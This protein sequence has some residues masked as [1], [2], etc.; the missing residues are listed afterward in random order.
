MK[1]I[2]IKIMAAMMVIGLLSSVALGIAGTILNF[3]SANDVM[4]KS[5]TETAKVAA[6]RVEKELQL[7]LTIATELGCTASVA[8]EEGGSLKRAA[9]IEDRL[10]RYGLSS[11]GI[12]GADGKNIATGADCSEEEF[13]KKAFDGKANISDFFLESKLMVYNTAVAAAPIWKGG[14]VGTSIIGVVYIVPSATFFEELAASIKVGEK[15][16]AYLL[17]GTGITM[18][19]VNTELVGVNSQELALEDASHKSRAEVEKKMMEGEPGF[20]TYTF[21]GNTEYIAYAPIANTAGWTIGINVE[22]QEFLG[23]VYVSLIINIIVALA[24]LVIAAVVSMFFANAIAKPITLCAGRLRKLADGDLTSPVPAATTNDE[25]GGLV[26][27]MKSVITELNAAIGDVSENLGEMANGNFALDITAEYK[28]DFGKIKTSLETIIDSLNRTLKQINENADQVS[29]GAK[30]VSSGANALSI[31]ATQQASSV[32]ELA[33]T[34]TELTAQAKKN[35]ESAAS[36][37][38]ETDDTVAEIIASREKMNEVTAAMDDI[39]D[40]SDEIS[41]IIRT[42]EDIAFQTNILALNAAVEAARAGEAGKGFAVVADEVRNLASKSAEA[43]NTTNALIADTVA[44]VNNGNAIVAETAQ[45]L[46]AVVEL[47]NNVRGR[48]DDIAKQSENQ[49]ESFA[50]LNIG[51]DQINGVVQTNSATSEESAAASEE[52]SAQAAA[53]NDLVSGFKLKG[54]EPEEEAVEEEI[55]EETEDTSEETEE[56]VADEA[57]VAEDAEQ[58]EAQSEVEE[59]ETV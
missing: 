20:S 12:L 1:S 11:G 19:N 8:D 26:R 45:S 30:Q 48:V 34:I 29:D 7:Y 38:K 52:L 14:V 43:A 13:F 18:C 50:M 41:N 23:G 9:A 49:A 25:I 56:A 35:A 3:S 51:L 33:A 54:E 4:S 32:Q 31:G 6:S 40:K 22:Q 57:P 10:A 36:A 59:Q 28:G 58:T 46:E 39:S 44:A 42:I 24:V 53:L 47:A 55:S 37:H 21:G 2:K 17:S 15:G 27:D 16:N 5:L